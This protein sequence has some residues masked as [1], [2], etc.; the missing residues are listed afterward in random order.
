MYKLQIEINAL[1]KSLNKTLRSYW[2]EQRRQHQWWH[3]A[4]GLKIRQKDLPPK[5]LEKATIRVTRHFYRSLDFD[6]LVGS[7]KPVIDALVTNGVL[8]DDNWKVTGP[9]IMNQ[10]HRAKKDGPLLEVTVEGQT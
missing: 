2:A 8:I 1:P 10:K 5:P 4:V 6:G 3:F 7:M 9:W